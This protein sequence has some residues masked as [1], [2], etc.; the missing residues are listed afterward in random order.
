MIDYSKVFNDIL[1]KDA[2]TRCVSPRYWDGKKDKPAVQNHRISI[3]TTCMNRLDDLKKTLPENIEDNLDYSNVEFVVL[4]YNS[5]DGLSDWI[6][7][8]MQPYI[9]RG[10]LNFYRTEEPRTYSMAHS[11]NIAFKLASGH[12]VNNVDADN[13]INKGFAKYLNLLAHQVP[14]RAVFAKGKRMLRGRLGFYRKEFMDLLGGYDE[15]SLLRAY[16][17]DDHDL[18]HRA[19]GLNFQMVWWGGQYY[20]ATPNHKKHQMDNFQNK[21]W[22]YTEKC[23]KILSFFNLFYGLYKA[24]R[25]GQWGK[26]TVVRNFLETIQV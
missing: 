4:D 18:L 6:K 20:K 24:N 13:F 22:K 7:S 12:I 10:L 25:G 5:S 11:R 1:N 26:A 9:D 23:N 15:N 8:D 3:C 19:F 17:H 14:E 16:G 21:D 2:W